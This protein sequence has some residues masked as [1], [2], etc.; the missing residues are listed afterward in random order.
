MDVLAKFD[1]LS[2]STEDLFKNCRQ[3]N[4]SDS[5]DFS[6]GEFSIAG[7]YSD[8]CDSIDMKRESAKKTK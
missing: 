5:S 1:T 6:E 7:A 8:Q 2:D 3:T 4:V